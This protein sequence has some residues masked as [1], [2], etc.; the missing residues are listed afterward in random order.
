[1]SQPGKPILSFEDHSQNYLQI[2]SIQSASVGIPGV[3]LG[4]QLTSTIG[5]LGAISSILFGNLILW[6]VGFTIISMAAPNRDNAIQNVQRYIGKVGGMA[7]AC[8]L[9]VAFLSWY[10]LQINTTV[11][12][13]QNAYTS[14]PTALRIGAAFGFLTA[15]LSSGGIYFIKKFSLI[16]F[17]ILCSML[18]YLFIISDSPIDFSQ[19]WVVS[20]SGTLAIFSG[21]LA[22]MINLPTFFRH[23]KS[24]ADSYLGLS[25]MTI[26]SIFFQIFPVLCGY[27]DLASFKSIS[28]FSNFILIAFTILSLVGI[29]LVNIY[30]ASA[31]WEM[32][33]PHRVSSK[34]YI[35]VGLLGTM[36]YTFLQ[37]SSPMLFLENMANNFIASLG[38]VL[39]LAF[40]VTIIVKHRPRPLE[41]IVNISSWFFGG[42]I[43]TIAQ[44]HTDPTSALI[45]SISASC[46]LFLSIIFLEE[47]VWATKKILS[48]TIR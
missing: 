29:N 20:F 8:L 15:L 45:M 37:I 32:I 14:I 35:I 31:G 34:E 16:S 38:A 21:A 23:S 42:T 5:P 26:F 11:S 41:K 48:R 1:M 43:G 24:K 33:F 10:I 2:T 13:I 3:L 25:L 17:P 4:A 18:V 30:F 9:I 19:P 39:L 44:V 7:A 47:T 6:M 12:I 46:V 27:T 36:A 40:L 28:A 22:G